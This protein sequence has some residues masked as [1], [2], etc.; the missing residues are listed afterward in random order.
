MDYIKYIV[1]K[2]IKI[3]TLIIIFSLCYAA[4]ET[5]FK[6]EEDPKK[7]WYWVNDC[8]KER[9]NYRTFEENGSTVVEISNDMVGDAMVTFEINDGVTTNEFIKVIKSGSTTGKIITQNKT[10][11]PSIRIIS[12]VMLKNGNP[13]YILE[14]NEK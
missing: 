8:L 11:T 7:T 5:W 2:S 12:V 9:I 14:C 4:Y 6:E 10:E 13:D 3:L 1:L